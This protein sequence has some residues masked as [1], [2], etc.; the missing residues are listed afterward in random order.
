MPAKRPDWQSP[1]RPDRTGIAS[2]IGRIAATERDIHPR[3]GVAGLTS[4]IERRR[5][6]EAGTAAPHEG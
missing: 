3:N 5:G 2:D 4:R 6:S 1:R